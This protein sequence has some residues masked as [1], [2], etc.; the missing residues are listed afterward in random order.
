MKRTIGLTV[1]ILLLNSTWSDAQDAYTHHSPSGGRMT[2][3]RQYFPNELNL[4]RKTPYEI[5]KP[6]QFK[7]IR[8]AAEEML[9]PEN[10]SRKWRGQP[11]RD[12][13]C[14]CAG[15]EAL[16]PG[17][18]PL[19]RKSLLYAFTLVC[20]GE[21]E[22]SKQIALPYL[23]KPDS[24]YSANLILGLLTI[25]YPENV[26]YLKKAFSIS[27]VK[28]FE[29]L[30]WFSFNTYEIKNQDRYQAFLRAWIACA[31]E[32]VKDTKGILPA[33][34]TIV[35]RI[36]LLSMQ[37]EPEIRPFYLKLKSQTTNRGRSGGGV[38][39]YYS[40]GMRVEGPPPNAMPP[41]QY[42]KPPQITQAQLQRLKEQVLQEKAEIEKK[43]REG[44]A[45]PEELSPTQMKLEW[46]QRKE[47]ELSGKETGTEKT[48]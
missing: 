30:D 45:K 27:P 4:I 31:A 15:I 36:E 48:K 29:V 47:K 23:D 25:R 34:F 46:I 3:C 44:S 21:Y 13:A 11:I 33:S 24:A 19:D 9:K 22:S 35:R 32:S 39:Y 43:I 10:N 42:R 7:R 2:V 28:T 26:Q 38:R 1:L 16:L 37:N 14:I 17:S 20:A 41:G 5:M 12:W 40:A 18:G 8:V 6:E